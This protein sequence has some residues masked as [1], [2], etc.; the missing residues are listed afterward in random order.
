[1][2]REKGDRGRKGDNQ[3]Q[4]KRTEKDTETHRGKDTQTDREGEH[5]ERRG[6]LLQ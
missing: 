1:M 2:Q 4:R 5:V 3:K 6:L